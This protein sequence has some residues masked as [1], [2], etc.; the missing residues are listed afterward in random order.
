MSSVETLNAIFVGSNLSQENYENALIAWSSLPTLQSNVPLGANGIPYCIAES[1]R[2]SLIDDYGWTI[3]DAGL[4]CPDFTI[5][6]LDHDGTNLNTQTV[7]H[8]DDASAPTDP[9]RTGYTFT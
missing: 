7:A 3:T 2:Q 9:T 4:D 1:A 6:F 8:G 5:N